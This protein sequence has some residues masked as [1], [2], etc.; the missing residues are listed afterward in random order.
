M[1][2]LCLVALLSFA[3]CKTPREK[4]ETR[5]VANIARLSAFAAVAPTAPPAT[6]ATVATLAKLT[7]FSG[8]YRDTNALLV[9]QEELANPTLRRALPLR[10]N[11]RS[12]AVDVANVLGLTKAEPGV[13]LDTAYDPSC[14]EESEDWQ[15]L[16]SV[17]YLFV[18]R[19]TLFREAQ[20]TG[21]QTFSP[22]VWEGDVS[23]FDFDSKGYQGGFALQAR[24]QESVR[25]RLGRDDANLK[26][27]LH[28]GARSTLDDTLRKVIPT[29]ESGDSVN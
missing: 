7:D 1:S 8:K 26:A 24:N 22:G 29:W 18:V 28:L 19:T 16:A 11:W 3:A 21:A 14:G 5:A 17:K 2:R 12:P 4:Y 10:L 20:M 27:D 9:H 25:T 6:A 23:V 15:R 13:E